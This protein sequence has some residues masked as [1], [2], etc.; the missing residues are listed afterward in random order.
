MVPLQSD[1]PVA[2]KFDEISLYP[3]DVENDLNKK[4]IY[5]PEW[6]KKAIDVGVNSV[7]TIYN[8]IAGLDHVTTPSHPKVQLEVL[9]TCQE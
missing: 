5:T 8:F 6:D 7:C 1:E 2:I 3:Q 4:A 9:K